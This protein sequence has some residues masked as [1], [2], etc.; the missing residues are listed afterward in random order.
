[1]NIGKLFFLKWITRGMCY[2]KWKLQTW[3]LSD[4]EKKNILC[5]VEQNYEIEKIHIYNLKSI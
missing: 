4:S 3:T 1:M 5:W 2:P